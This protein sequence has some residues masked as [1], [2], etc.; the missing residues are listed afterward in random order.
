MRFVRT[1]RRS[2]FF[3]CSSSPVSAIPVAHYVLWGH[4]GHT[5][6]GGM[7]AGERSM[8]ERAYIVSVKYRTWQPSSAV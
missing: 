3:C 8:R 7:C 1:L 6:A 4:E 2:F 5:M